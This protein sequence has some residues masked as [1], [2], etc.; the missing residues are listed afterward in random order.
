MGIANYKYVVKRVTFQMEQ[1]LACTIISCQVFTHNKRGPSDLDRSTEFCLKRLIYRYI[2]KIGFAPDDPLVGPFLSPEP[3]LE[4]ILIWSTGRCYI[5]NIRAIDLVV[6]NKWIV[7]C[8][9]YVSQRK[10][11]DLH[12]E[13]ILIT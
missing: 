8:F 3:Y 5:L 9:H 10:L 11:C 2:L 6:S 1:H 13:D 4:Q 7:L 12:D